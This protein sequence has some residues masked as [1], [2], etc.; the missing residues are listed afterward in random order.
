M[1]HRSRTGRYWFYRNSSPWQEAEAR[2]ASIILNI[3][4]IAIAMSVPVVVFWCLPE[5]AHG[6]L[7]YAIGI[8]VG[9]AVYLPFIWLDMRLSRDG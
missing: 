9:L 3:F 5:L 4:G 2:I 8:A 1:Y 6:S 7:R